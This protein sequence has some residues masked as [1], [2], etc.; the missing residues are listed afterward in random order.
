MVLVSLPLVIEYNMIH[1]PRACETNA[2]HL[3]HL[4]YGAKPKE[5]ECTL[6]VTFLCHLHQCCEFQLCERVGEATTSP[7]K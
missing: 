6:K 2:G 3:L 7:H 4:F 1:G 5:E